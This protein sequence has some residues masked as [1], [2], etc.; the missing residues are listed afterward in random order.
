[1][2]Q[3]KNCGKD[4]ILDSINILTQ[5][6]GCLDVRQANRRGLQSKRI[7]NHPQLNY[8]NRP[9]VIWTEGVFDH[10]F[11][12]VRWTKVCERVWRGGGGGGANTRD[13][14]QNCLLIKRKRSLVGR[15]NT[16]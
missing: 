13:C 2:F 16:P 4:L 15:F 6:I 5:T 1:M 12:L 7:Y 10:N 8:P 9:N 14:M 11:A 3:F